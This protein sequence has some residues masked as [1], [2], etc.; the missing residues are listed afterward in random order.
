MN[1]PGWFRHQRIA[2][3]ATVR[4][5]GQVSWAE[6]VREFL[7]REMRGAGWEGVQMARYGR[8]EDRIHRILDR[9]AHSR[10]LTRW[11]LAAVVA[12]GAPLAYAVA[13]VQA[14][15]SQQGAIARGMLSGGRMPWAGIFGSGPW[16]P[17]LSRSWGWL[18]TF[19]TGAWQ[20]TISHG[21]AIKC[22]IR[23]PRCR[24]RC[25]ASFRR[26][27]RLPCEPKRRP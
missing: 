27:Y 7:R 18:G 26:C 8:P 5:P 24:P 3:V 9:T 12:L 13:A 16:A 1:W 21:C 6:I 2:R 23:F 10:G 15:P 20:A 4:T 25:Y 22:T 11:G 19:G 14:T 17:H